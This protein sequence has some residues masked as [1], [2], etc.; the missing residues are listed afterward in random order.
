MQGNIYQVNKW[1]NQKVSKNAY[2]LQ[3]IF[4]FCNG[5]L[6]K[7]VLLLRKDVFPL[8]IWIAGKDLM[9]LHYLNKKYFYSELNLNLKGITDK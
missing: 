4:I 1:I 7:F 6:N 3:F 5:D 2:I 9:K 8:S